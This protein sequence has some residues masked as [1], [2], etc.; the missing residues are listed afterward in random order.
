MPAALA[1]RCVE[2]TSRP[3]DGV[4]VRGVGR[5]RYV[6]PFFLRVDLKFSKK[7]PGS[8]G[9]GSGNHVFKRID[10]FAVFGLPF[11]PC[12]H[13]FFHRHGNAAPERG[14]NPLESPYAFPGRKRRR[15]FPTILTA[16]REI[17]PRFGKIPRGGRKNR[18]ARPRPNAE[19]YFCSSVNSASITSSP[20]EGDSPPAGAS[21]AAWASAP[22]ASSCCFL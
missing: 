15:I 22:A 12:C 10:P 18:G 4:H 17:S 1:R 20:E 7:L 21:P 3:D 16:T 11:L 14:Y 2:I 9:T 13:I 8:F 5:V 19:T 6:H